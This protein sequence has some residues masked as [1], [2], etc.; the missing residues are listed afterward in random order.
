MVKKT[1]LNNLKIKEN[2]N[3]SEHTTISLGGD[4]KYFIVCKS[5]D[6]ILEALDFAKKRSLPAQLI[7]GGSNIIF[8]DKGFDGIVI[9]N[10]I[11]GISEKEKDDHVFI[12][13]GAGEE[14][15]NF[16][17]YCVEK[18]YSGIECLSGIPGSV[19]AMPV[20]NVGAYGQETSEVLESVKVIDRNDLNLKTFSKEECQFGYRMSKFKSSDKD[21]YVIVE[22]NFKLHINKDPE[23]KYKALGE[24]LNQNESFKNSDDVKSKLK[25]VRDTVISIRKEKSMVIDKADINSRSC[26]SFFMNPVLNENEFSEFSKLCNDLK[27]DFPFFKNDN[28]YKIPAAWLIENSGF[29]KGFRNGGVGISQNHTLALINIDGTTKELLELSE[30]IKNTVNNKFGIKLQTEPEIIS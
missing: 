12:T 3:L 27:T 28:N 21:K 1:S 18:S 26:G 6:E 10:N 30:E 5:S 24:R 22:V 9:K 25:I 14:L 11:K 17:E 23:I 13:V 20:Q 29:P 2:V 7:S 4:A 15:D 8:P 19:G 16:V